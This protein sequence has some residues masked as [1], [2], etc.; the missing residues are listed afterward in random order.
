[1]FGY[2]AQ[3][4]YYTDAETGLI[5]CGHRYYDPAKGR[6]LT[7]DPV[8]YAGGVD[9][10]GYCTDHPV[11]ESDPLGE[12]SETFPYRQGL[13]ECLDLAQGQYDETVRDI[14]D[15]IR[16]SVKRMAC[17]AN[18]RVDQGERIEECYANDAKKTINDY[19]NSFCGQEWFDPTW[20]PPVTPWGPIPPWEWAPL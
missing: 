14:C 3:W 12:T 8:G 11:Y 20:H 10:Y 1:M 7:R 4:G 6:W 19:L 17:Y 2:G 5:L 15:H 16:N 18:A 13:Q 9:L